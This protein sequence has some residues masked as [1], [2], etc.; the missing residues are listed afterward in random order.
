MVSY[1]VHMKTLIYSTRTIVDIHLRRIYILKLR[2]RKRG[3]I[4]YLI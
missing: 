4:Q 2:G 3:I 1:I